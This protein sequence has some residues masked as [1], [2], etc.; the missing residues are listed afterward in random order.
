M[1]GLIAGVWVF[2]DAW[3]RLE[4]FVTSGELETATLADL[5]GVPFWA[6]AVAVAV[7]AALTFRLIG[8]FE[9]RRKDVS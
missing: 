4:G 3:V 2:A 9:A 1:V 7:I 6:I 5:I 8:A